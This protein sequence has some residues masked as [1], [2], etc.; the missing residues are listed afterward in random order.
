MKEARRTVTVELYCYDL[1]PR[2]S[3][4]YLGSGAAIHGAAATV[5]CPVLTASTSVQRG[6]CAALL[7]ALPSTTTLCACYVPAMITLLGLH[8]FLCSRY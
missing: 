6:S 4:C 2:R 8:P 1:P 5:H 7:A 3:L